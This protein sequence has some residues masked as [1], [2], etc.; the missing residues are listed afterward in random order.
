[1]E[2]KLDKKAAIS[3]LE[4]L[5]QHMNSHTK[6]A[7]LQAVIEFIQESIHE[8]PDD[9]DERAALID[10]IE[11]ELALCASPEDRKRIIKLYT[12][13]GANDFNGIIVLPAGSDCMLKK[14][15]EEGGDYAGSNL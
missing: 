13:L 9:P 5:Q 12:D 10:K 15:N 11:Y 2:T 8:I 3:V 4:A 1:M 14:D 7:A 6:K